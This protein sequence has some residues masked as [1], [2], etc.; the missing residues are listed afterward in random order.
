LAGIDVV[1]AISE[2]EISEGV[3]LAFFTDKNSSM[4]DAD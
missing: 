1:N 3:G 4:V 2:I